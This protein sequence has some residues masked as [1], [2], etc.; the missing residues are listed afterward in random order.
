MAQRA[1][2]IVVS[3]PFPQWPL[4]TRLPLLRGLHQIKVTAPEAAGHR[5]PEPLSKGLWQAH[6]GSLT[7]PFKMRACKVILSAACAK[8]GSAGSELRTVHLEPLGSWAPDQ[9]AVL[10][11]ACL[12]T[13][14]R[15]VRARGG[16]ER[17]D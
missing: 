5:D 12:V 9:D 14:P 13:G 17:N 16:G 1:A 10:G 7:T 2:G 6:L 15:A 8:A 4:P 3:H 11:G